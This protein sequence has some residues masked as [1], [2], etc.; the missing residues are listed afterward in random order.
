MISEL[1]LIIKKMKTKTYDN[2]KKSLFVQY[3][4]QND[5]CSHEVC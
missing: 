2:P 1:Q 3:E 5:S 4:V